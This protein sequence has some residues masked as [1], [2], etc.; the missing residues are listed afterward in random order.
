MKYKLARL[1]LAAAALALGTVRAADIT[2]ATGSTGNWDSPGNWYGGVTPGAGD[3]IVISS[4]TAVIPS[5]LTVTTSNAAIGV[6]AG[7]TASV[8]LSGYWNNTDTLYIGHTGLGS[9]AI[10]N[11]GTLQ[12]GSAK[13]LY[14]GYSG[15]GVLVIDEGGVLKRSGGTDI[16]IG[17]T[18]NASDIGTATPVGSGS[19]VV[20]G[21][22]D[23]PGSYLRIGAGGDGYLYVGQTGT[24]NATGMRLTYQS[25]NSTGTA[26]ID[27][28]WNSTGYIIAS[29]WGSSYFEVG[30][31][32][33]ALI[34]DYFSIGQ[35]DGTGN[36]LT[37]TS[38]ATIAGYL[39]TTNAFQVANRMAATVDITETGTVVVGT[40]IYVGNA[41]TATGTLNVAGVVNVN[42]ANSATA[43]TQL[44][45]GT[46]G[47]GYLNVLGTGTVISTP[48]IMLA[49]NA[50]SYGELNIASGGYWDGAGQLY[51]GYGGVGALHVASG[52]TFFA[53]QGVYLAQTGTATVT[54]DGYWEN[55]S[56]LIYTGIGGRGV[57]TITE[58]GTVKGANSF[59]VA[60]TGDGNTDTGDS[61]VYVHGVLDN[62]TYTIGVGYAGQGRMDVYST[63]TV[64]AGDM[65]VGDRIA[66]TGTLTLHDG[67]ILITNGDIF[68]IGNSGK[69]VLIV[70][71]GAAILT[72]NDRL[73]GTSLDFTLGNAAGSSGTVHLS[74]TLLTAHT[75]KNGALGTGYLDIR[76]T[77]RVTAGGGYTQ[78][79]A[80]TLKVELDT[81]RREDTLF[82]DLSAPLIEAGGK[83]TLSGTLLVTGSAVAD[84]PEFEWVNNQAKAGTLTGIPVLRATGGITGDFDTVE[85]EGLIIPAT[86]PDFIR[87][88]G[89][90]INE[91][92]PVDTR[93]D[94]GYG[95]AWKAGVNSAHGTF[96]LD[97]G[98]T[99]INDL[100]L[101]DRAGLTFDTGWDGK[102][103]T[104]KGPGT[105]VLTVQNAYTGA[106]TVDDGILRFAGPVNITLGD[107]IVNSGTI[108]FG[109]LDA[110]GVAATPAPNVDP[111]LTAGDFRTIHAA[112]LS[113]TGGVYRMSF[114][115]A[116]GAG[117]KLVIA[118]DAAAGIHQF[119]ITL[120][121]T[122]GG[123]PTGAE[124][125]PEL[126][127]IGGV[128]Q[129][130][131]A[132]NVIIDGVSSGTSFDRGAFHYEVVTDSVAGTLKIVPVSMGA[133]YRAPINGVLAAPLS[134]L[135][136]DQQDNLA[137]RFGELRSPRE[138]GAGFDLW[139]R[140]H[141]ATAS[142]GGG[143]TDM[144]LADIDLWGAEIGA[145]HTWRLDAE[146]VTI[147]LYASVGNASQDYN[148]GAGA[149]TRESD[150]LG[151]GLYAAWLADSG[152]FANATLSSVNYDNTLDAAN[153]A[154]DHTTAD[155]TDRAFGASVEIG[156]R[157]Q[158][159][160]GFFA[161]PSLQGTLARLTLAS[162]T[163]GGLMDD[164][165]TPSYVFGVR[166]SSATITRARAAIRAG[167]A[168]EI[169]GL[170]WL[171]L[172]ARAGFIRETSSGGELAIGPEKWSPNLDGNRYEAGLGLYWQPF[173]RGQLYF[174]YEYAAGDNY[175]K[176]WALSLGLRLSL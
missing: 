163:T 144:R 62:A 93:Y 11:G 53:A 125:I 110:A 31:T 42:G 170:G 52:G 82:P 61:N 127:L 122:G 30:Q 147:G 24:V 99:F 176:P 18:H 124:P 168:W 69:G 136:F 12:L 159:G 155:Y 160:A 3:N 102:S 32:G 2:W 152:W 134:L 17:G 51:I 101:S 174:D 167:R 72:D 19:I 71:E 162:Y 126:A 75:I 157:I 132:P 9:L 133:E 20:N 116:T 123:M 37:A 92:G 94:V 8:D 35:G 43:S 21:L 103:L 140:G 46:T 154:G 135:W 141:A 25:F 114:D 166:G 117:D 29:H 164:G 130:T 33:T 97:E 67:S 10:H 158:I 28:V 22:L 150:L 44:D 76:S 131:L 128:N 50:N 73:N 139:A 77:S 60:G 40:R 105:L 79:A 47:T 7:A 66:A 63:G 115:L 172:A 49:R 48:R 96:T 87:G 109:S 89:L 74:G 156:R 148:R 175:E 88:G 107:L 14:V 145:D 138:T 112:S 64:I 173:N 68:R 38:T 171:E 13:F 27:G 121:N 165:V 6:P 81:G 86:L 34:G 55:R 58:T 59:R 36:P 143:S 104:K 80:S 57:F 5:V 108:D 70:E 106:T 45:I 161:E 90:K 169:N 39:K 129:A 111:S 137:R 23:T 95:L 26:I 149:A 153:P 41:A 100:Q 113:G 65:Y 1:A 151:F 91:G 146:R 54:V 83:A 16:Y 119:D 120:K 84:I 98:K 4:G 78:N 85:I 142:V 15:T 118:G 56:G